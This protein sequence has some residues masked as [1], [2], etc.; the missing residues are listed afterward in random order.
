MP[1]F[2]SRTG[3]VDEGLG[4]RAAG[5]GLEGDAG[6]FPAYPQTLRDQFGIGGDDGRRERAEEPVRP[7]RR[8]SPAP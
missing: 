8:P 5:M 2:A 3:A 1:R 7:L 4:H 6:G